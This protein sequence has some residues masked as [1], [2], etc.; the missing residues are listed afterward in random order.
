VV[1]LA[2]VGTIVLLLSS[3]A[4][5]S[6]HGKPATWVSILKLLLGV[7]LLVVAYRQYEKRPR[8]D[9]PPRMPSWMK[10]IDH[11]DPRRSAGLAVGLS[12]VNP[13][14]LILTLGAAAAIAGTGI[15]GGKQAI[16]LVVFII[17]ASLGAAIPVGIDLVMGERGQHILVGLRNWMARNNSVIMAVLCVI[18]GAKL[19]GDAITGFSS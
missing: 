5:A 1:G 17:I 4:S 11:F 14:N 10:N 6:D 13:K 19:I 16:A 2:V 9:G 3:G 18:I 8:G 15:S 7:G 12:A